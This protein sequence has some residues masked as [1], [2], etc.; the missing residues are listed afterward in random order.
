MRKIALSSLLFAFT[1]GVVYPD[2]PPP[3]RV[4]V[5]RQGQRAIDEDSRIVLRDF[6]VRLVESASFN[7]RDD[8]QALN[9]PV[10]LV[11]QRYR[12]LCAGEYLLV[13]FE[14][15]A[16]IRV[17]QREID[18]VEIVI[19]WN[20][21]YANAVFAIDKEGRVIAFEKYDGNTAV[22]LRKALGSAMD[23]ATDDPPQD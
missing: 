3:A 5:M 18:V 7:T 2:E 23:S 8:A 9:Q 13:S 22:K 10:A 6:A 21:Q 1:S 14:N 4:S 16:R 17:L 11:Q 20:D 12:K 15:P 19:G